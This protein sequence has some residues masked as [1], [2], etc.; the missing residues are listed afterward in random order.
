MRL[1]KAGVKVV[2]LD[3][4]KTFVLGWMVYLSWTAV[5]EIVYVRVIVCARL[6]CRTLV[7]IRRDSKAAGGL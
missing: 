3:S 7:V 5:A 4:T 1:F 6:F 2:A